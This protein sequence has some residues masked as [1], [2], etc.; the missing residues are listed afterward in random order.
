MWRLICNSPGYHSFHCL[1]QNNTNRRIDV[2][3]SDKR[4]RGDPTFVVEEIHPE[5][6]ECRIWLIRQKNCINLLSRFVT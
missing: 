3:L 4:T 6:G 1:S 2:I 5:L